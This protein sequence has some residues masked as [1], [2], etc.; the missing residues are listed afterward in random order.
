M[1]ATRTFLKKCPL[2]DKLPK[3]KNSGNIAVN[4]KHSL[5]RQNFIDCLDLLLSNM[6][7]CGDC[8]SYLRQQVAQRQEDNIV[9]D[10]GFDNISLFG[11]LDETFLAQW[12]S[13]HL[14]VPMGVV[15][16]A[17]VKEPQFV[18]QAA[19]ALL[20]IGS[21]A[22]VPELCK[23]RAVMMSSLNRRY[24]EVGE[25]AE[26]FQSADRKLLSPN[27][28]VNWL[29]GVYVVTF[30]TDGSATHVE[31]RPT[32]CEIPV[33]DDIQFNTEFVII[34]NWDDAAAQVERGRTK[35]KFK[36]MFSKNQGPNLVQTWCGR[37]DGWATVAAACVAEVQ[38]NL[39]KQVAEDVAAAA[40]SFI[41]PVKAKRAEATA[42]ART[43]LAERKQ[44]TAK[45]RRV[46]LVGLAA[47]PI[48]RTAPPS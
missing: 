36:D 15:G 42:R 5:E 10:D 13:D 29:H 6:S 3:F 24:H 22:K 31:H 35:Y 12:V 30:G 47:A 32:R 37:A 11:R 25:R 44:E 45:R 4:Q 48:A 17:K 38:R 9:G 41:T 2:V 43:M 18:R 20:N 8:A 40:E 1:S 23:Q 33:P 19:Q 26:L 21:S 7:L 28:T 14:K 46:S 16:L 39:S 27:G 34:N